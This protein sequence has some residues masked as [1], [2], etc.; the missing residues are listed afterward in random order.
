MTETRLITRRTLQPMNSKFPPF[1]KIKIVYYL[2]H[3]GLWYVGYIVCFCWFTPLT[4]CFCGQIVYPPD[5]FTHNSE[6][7]KIRAFTEIFRYQVNI[8]QST[9]KFFV[10]NFK[11]PSKM[12]GIC[13]E[14]MYFILMFYLKTLD[15]LRARKCF[16]NSLWVASEYPLNVSC[17]TWP[18]AGVCILAQA[19]EDK[20]L[21]AEGF[22]TLLSQLV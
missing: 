21:T 8:F 3:K 18:I 11:V 17:F 6:L 10:W 19:S 14:H 5:R 4:V 16:R 2:N 12:R 15:I 1:K 13:I 22:Q 7:F 20:T 9:S